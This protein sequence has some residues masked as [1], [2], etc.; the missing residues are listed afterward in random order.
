MNEEDSGAGNRILIV[1]DEKSLAIGLKFN[2]EEDGYVASIAKDGREA[3]KMFGKGN[4]DL[5]ILD[6][7]LP[8]VDGFQVAEEMRQES[9]QIPILM[10]TART[11]VQD[12]VRG[13][14]TGADDYMAK[15]FHLAE[16][17]VRIKG[18]LKRKQW[19]K[20]ITA[21][22]PVYRFGDNFVDFSKLECSSGRRKFKLTA[23]E[24]VLLRYLIENR[25]RNVTRQE[26][27]E[28]VWQI[29]SEIE[30]R[31][32]DNFIVR[33]R[34]LFEPDP[35]MPVFIKSVRSVGYMFSDDES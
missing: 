23:R 16:L 17:L 8:F 25:G 33:L 15:P 4:F 21:S 20:Q 10:L 7:M 32:V 28:N 3:L 30:T 11:G 18:M 31:T 29:S 12:R 19:Y 22:T 26:L 2:L 5:V 27:L 24:A 34:R 35:S 14:E 13:L 9:P 1:E 6:I